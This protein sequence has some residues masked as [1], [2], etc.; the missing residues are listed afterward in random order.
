MEE[1]DYDFSGKTILLAEDIEI[2]RT[3]IA[4]FLEETGVAI[5]NADNGYAAVE[6]F[7]AAP[8]KYKAIL[9][10]IQ[11]PVLD[12]LNAARQIRASGLPNALAVPII[13]MTGDAQKEDIELSAQAGM[14]GH[15]VKP[16]DIPELLDAL[17]EAMG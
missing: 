10:D 16:I 13:A 6:M 1:T 3:L 9:M 17:S 15:I 7:K 8:G 2:N 14:N 11:M 5:D 4:L 12:G